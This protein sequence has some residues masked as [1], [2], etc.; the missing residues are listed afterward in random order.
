MNDIRALED[1]IK[2]ELDVQN[3]VPAEEG[4]NSETLSQ[5]GSEQSQE[6]SEQ[7]QEASEQISQDGSEQ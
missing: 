4:Q 1:K 2:A 6:N 5:N 3:C 7:S